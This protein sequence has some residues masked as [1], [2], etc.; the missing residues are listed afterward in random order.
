MLQPV[1]VT[2]LGGSDR[3]PGVLPE[4]GGALHPLATYKGVGI[5]VG[6]RPLVA[7]LVERLLAS[8]GFGPVTIAG[9]ARVYEP[10]GLPARVIDT[11]ASVAQNLRAAIEA[12]TTGPLAVV[13]CDVLPSVAELAELRARYAEAGPCALWFPLVRVP[14]DPGELGAFAWKPAYTVVLESGERVP[15]LPGHLGILDPAQLRL[16]LLY[17]LLDSAYRTRNHSVVYRRGVMLRTVLFSLLAQDLML[18]ARL[19][20]PSRTATI[21]GSGLRLARELRAG[22][23]RLAEL[24]QLVGRIFLH[25]HASGIRYP[26]L[27]MVSLAEDIDT[28]EEARAVQGEIEP[29]RNA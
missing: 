7:W 22:R 11:D 20:A 14:K 24:E 10:L 29:L 18:L 3:K 25:Q 28:E 26:I 8:R 4:S 16:P 15:V 23:L 19:R 1:P 2:I 12:R 13:S 6:G 5:R 27:E 21:L 17:R 9:P